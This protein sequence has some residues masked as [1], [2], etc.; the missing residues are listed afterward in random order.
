MR[1]NIHVHL[2]SADHV[3][4][5][6]LYYLIR[7]ALHAAVRANLQPIAGIPVTTEDLKQ[8]DLSLDRYRWPWPD[9]TW[10]ALQLDAG[11]MLPELV[12]VHRLT[13]LLVAVSRASRP[14][15]RRSLGVSD[16]ERFGDFLKGLVRRAEAHQRAQRP[17]PLRD[18]V[19]DVVR[20]LYE[21]HERAVAH[22]GRVTQRELWQAFLKSP[23]GDGYREVVALAL[24]FDE[25]FAYEELPD[26][27]VFPS[28]SYA[29]Q[30]EELAGLAEEVNAAGGTRLLPFLGVE[31]RGHD[32]GS[33]RR[34]VEQ[35]VGRD[36]PFKGLK[37]Y[38]PMGVLPA[39]DRLDGVFDDCQ[40]AGIPIIS[41]CSMGGAGV[42]G[43]LRNYAD[44]AH[45]YKW[46]NVLDRLARRAQERQTGVFRL[47]LAHFSQLEQADASSWSDE[48]IQLMQR[49]GAGSHVKVYADVAFN[50]VGTGQEYYRR[51]VEKVRALGLQS[52]VLFGSDWWNYL[53]ECDDERRYTE[54]L[55]IDEGFW[56]TQELDAAADDF[57]KDV[58]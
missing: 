16:A 4:A 31:P 33:L 44:L 43:R 41:H 38:P 53:Y 6:Q 11:G 46:I 48:I 30:L 26:I 51:N 36:K 58:L 15:I 54:Q 39:D 5:A 20:E 29:E 17:F 19:C 45:P 56:R 3:P 2:F 34:F 1:T 50:V 55:Q 32:R 35:R 8:L 47:C 22:A 27:G 13:N 24:N 25:A 42:R 10:A 23:G 12:D 57:L 14:A 28:V 37:F 7:G 52:H 40:D 49:Y 9:F 18:A 21:A